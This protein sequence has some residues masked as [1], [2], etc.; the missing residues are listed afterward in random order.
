[1]KNILT[2]TLSELKV[3]HTHTFTDNL[4]S[5]NPDRDNLYGLSFMLSIYGIKSKGHYIEKKD[6]TD[7]PL[8]FIAHTNTG[9]VLVTELTEDK[10]LCHNEG[11][12]RYIYIDF[13]KELWTGYLLL[14]EQNAESGEIDY[15]VHRKNERCETLK[16]IALISS[17]LALA[18]G[19]S[20]LSLAAITLPIAIYLV[21]CLVGIGGSMNLLRTQWGSYSRTGDMI[22]NIF[23]KGDCI[24]V[25]HSP[26][27]RVS[28]GISWAEIGF[29]YFLT[30]FLLL[31]L[32]PE[33]FP[34]VGLINV[35]A[36]LFT[37]WSLWYQRVRI[38][39]Y[40]P[41]CLI[42]LLVIWGLF[43]TYI[44]SGLSFTQFQPL[45][46][47]STPVYVIT[48][49][50]THYYSRKEEDLF[51]LEKTATS[52]RALLC[53]KETLSL[54]LNNQPFIKVTSEDSCILLGNPTASRCITIISNPL[55]KPCATAH[56]YLEWLLLDNN[57]IQIRYI[58]ATKNAPMYLAS[59]YLVGAFIR[60][61][62]APINDWFKMDAA[63]RK[64]LLG[65][66]K[67]R[68]DDTVTE[69]E[70]LRHKAFINRNNILWTPTILI[71]GHRIPSAY[72][73]E[74]LAFAL[75]E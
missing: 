40:C 36:L 6:L 18:G 66:I 51:T 21:L 67:K 24:A 44:F 43:A 22:C 33:L 29:S 30:S 2:V 75:F 59:Q 52:Y 41:L 12:R 61:G 72:S 16:G 13:F 42:I 17:L 28:L 56:K 71:N 63:D 68:E 69:Q 39:T 48:S 19:A 1:M 53:R 11:G 15:P 32:H 54:I 25:A 26:G 34:T 55:C 64:Q 74:D 62:T 50:L 58:F 49:L 8:P 31:A 7:I 70:L 3:R 73:I 57:D 5:S 65:L 14:L 37:F 9:F 35:F 60:H 27:A 23:S 4:F 47:L 45:H 38:K 10:V 20:V 46:L